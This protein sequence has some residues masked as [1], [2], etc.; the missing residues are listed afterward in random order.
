MVN[1]HEL[2]VFLAVIEEGNFSEAG[3]RLHLSQPAVSQSIRGLEQ[4]VGAALFVRQGRQVRLT[5]AG[6]TLEPM[7]RELLGV[8][9]RLEE[10]MSAL[11]GTVAGEI[12]VGCSTAS[13]KYLLP[14]L[15]AR[16]RRDYPDVRVNVQVTS[17]EGVLRGLLDGHLALGV[18]SKR[19]DHP[20]LAVQHFFDDDIALIVPAGHRWARFRQIYPDDLLD[21]PIILREEGAGTREVLEEALAER[22]ISRDMLNVAMVLG[23]AEAIE[24]AVE[25]GL[26]VAF[27]SRLAAAHGVALGRVVEVAVEG[28]ELTR[29]ITMAYNRR[30]PLTRAQAAL[31]DFVALA[32]IEL[33][34]VAAKAA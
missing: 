18:S 31:W 1:L 12:T 13:G 26:G 28:L 23:N 5:E 4:R 17:R 16:F 3:R 9:R 30:F 25:E 19:L 2:D 8:A 14:R 27:I 21:E 22:G 6:Q 34:V 7:A 29:P 24:V 15:I 32:D 33:G 20:D 10:T 11:E